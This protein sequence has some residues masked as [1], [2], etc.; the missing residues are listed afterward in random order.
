MKA[1]WEKDYWFE[2]SILETQGR[3]RTYRFQKNNFENLSLKKYSCS[4]H[5]IDVYETSFGCFFT[6]P[7]EKILGKPPKSNP[8]SIVLRMSSMQ[9]ARKTSQKRGAQALTKRISIRGRGRADRFST[10]SHQ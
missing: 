7:T 4:R 9:S 8:L 10:S 1:L 2:R 6:E 3:S 5:D